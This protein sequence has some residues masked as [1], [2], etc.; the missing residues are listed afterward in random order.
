MFWGFFNTYKGFLAAKKSLKECDLA[1][2]AFCAASISPP[3][4][5][6]LGGISLVPGLLLLLRCVVAFDLVDWV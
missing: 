6:I 2:S 4:V 1:R 3:G 5:V